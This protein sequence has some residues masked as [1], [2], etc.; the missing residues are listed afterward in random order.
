MSRLRTFTL[1][2]GAVVG[3]VCL[4]L[5]LASVLFD[6]RFL[7]FRSGSM[8]PEIPAGSVALARP[9]PAAELAN[10]DVVSVIASNGV[11][12]THR[13]VSI[14]GDGPER[15]LTLRGDANTTPDAETYTVAEADR[16]F[17]SVPG[18]GYVVAWF[19]SP[20]GLFVLGGSAVGIVVLGFGRRRRRPAGGKHRRRA[21]LIAPISA[22]LL[23]VPMTSLTSAA[24]TD[25]AAVTSGT[26]S[27]HSVV[28]QAKPACTNEGGLLGLLGFA[29]LT[30]SH[31]D[32]RYEYAWSAVRVSNGAQLQSGVI[33]PSGGA[34]S[35]V[36][37]DISTSLLNLGVG[38]QNVDVIVRSRLTQ[39][40][41]W[42]APTVTTSRVH[43]I[44]LLVGLSVRCESA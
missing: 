2:A 31:V 44:S 19:G 12:V 40:P 21:A 7:V 4:V 42:V 28:S 18:V 14:T 33:T 22:A 9:V 39:S 35:D 6:I 23:V 13:I 24:F 16:V 29:R 15:V 34:G 17:W 30:W 36:T 37:L 11:R 26:I 3:T 27:A 43:T 5:A 32:T 25:S 38:G 41:T 1:T 8:G 20:I 10:G